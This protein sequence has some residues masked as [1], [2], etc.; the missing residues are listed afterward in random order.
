MICPVDFKT[1]IDDICY[2]AGCI[3]AGGDML[4]R[5]DKCRSPTESTLDCIVLCEDCDDPDVWEGVYD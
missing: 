2:G 4:T 1:C 5:C 3:R